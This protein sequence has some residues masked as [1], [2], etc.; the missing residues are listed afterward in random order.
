ML[1]L[2]MRSCEQKVWFKLVKMYI[3]FGDYTMVMKDVISRGSW[4]KSIQEPSALILQLSSK[5]KIFQ[6]K[7]LEKHA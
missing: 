7:N 2:N 3:D 6:N 1:S 4:V 5:S